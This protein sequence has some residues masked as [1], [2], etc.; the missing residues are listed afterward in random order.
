M[1]ALHAHV[2]VLI[3]GELHAQFNGVAPETR[4]E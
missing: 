1:L 4:R 3:V 2:V